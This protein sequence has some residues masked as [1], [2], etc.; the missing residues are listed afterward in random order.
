MSLFE[1]LFRK[2]K[3]LQEFE[4]LQEKENIPSL[5]ELSEVKEIKECE[6]RNILETQKIKEVFAK[7]IKIDDFGGWGYFYIRLED[8]SFL[9]TTSYFPMTDQ[10]GNVT[11][12]ITVLGGLSYRRVTLPERLTSIIKY[13]L[14]E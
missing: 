8:K 10:D 13:T 14:S 5:S 2:P 4:E 12:D 6:F 11:D 3:E 7:R 9:K 1:K